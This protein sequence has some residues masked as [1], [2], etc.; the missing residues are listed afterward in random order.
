[1]PA[2]TDIENSIVYAESVILEC[3]GSNA[4]MLVA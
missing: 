3:F 2:A 1:M 4:G